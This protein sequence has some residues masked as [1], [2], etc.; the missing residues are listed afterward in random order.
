MNKDA[1][2]L[3]V[4]PLVAIGPEVAG[5]GSSPP[6]PEGAVSRRPGTCSRCLSGTIAAIIG[7]AMP[8]G[9]GHDRHHA[10]SPCT[11]DQRQSPS[12]AIADALSGF[13]NP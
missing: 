3:R 4:Q 9:A 6:V 11:G 8:I 1:F 7:K 10:W 13:S 2:K 12:T 5:S